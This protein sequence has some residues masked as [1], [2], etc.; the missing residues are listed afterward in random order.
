MDH[1]QNDYLMHH[2]IKGMKWGIRKDRS[3]GS[4]RSAARKKARA[5]AKAERKKNRAANKA[6]IKDRRNASKNRRLLS[7]SDL[8]SRIK[9][10]EKEKK[11]RDLTNDDVN[12]GKKAARDTMNTFGSTAAKNAAKVAAFGIVGGATYVGRKYIEF[13][14]NPKNTEQGKKFN[15]REAIGED[16]GKWVAEK[17]AFWKK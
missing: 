12:P 7:D 9:R 1:N 8:D 2:G 10:L 13:K 6:I 16:I 5:E 4:A 3:S 11:L 14:V 15:L 17:P